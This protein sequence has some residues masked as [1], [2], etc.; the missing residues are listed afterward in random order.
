MIDQNVCM[1]L[2]LNFQ[3]QQAK[4]TQ[5]KQALQRQLEEQKQQTEELRGKLNKMTDGWAQETSFMNQLKGLMQQ[6]SA[7]HD[8]YPPT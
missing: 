5:D 4:D 6:M 2:L 1:T 3:A 7:H 8:A